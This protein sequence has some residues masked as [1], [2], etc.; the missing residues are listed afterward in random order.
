MHFTTDYARFYK[1]RSKEEIKEITKQAAERDA[2]RSLLKIYPTAT[3]IKVRTE[4]CTNSLYEGLVE[5]KGWYCAEA[6]ADVSIKDKKIVSVSKANFFCY[7]GVN[8]LYPTARH[9]RN[10]ARLDARNR[11]VEAYP[12]V[13]NVKVIN[14]H[15]L[16]TSPGGYYQAWAVGEIG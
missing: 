15:G 2:R 5:S 4:F 11:L 3:N 9:A 6:I 12:G 10:A 8:S 7:G 16:F 13:R 14:E 1:D